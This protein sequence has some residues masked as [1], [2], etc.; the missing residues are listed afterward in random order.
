MTG[1]YSRW[2]ATETAAA[3]AHD[4]G[5]DPFACIPDP[6]AEYEGTV[7]ELAAPDTA[8]KECAP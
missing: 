3:L 1:D 2:L 8:P 4:T 7:L 5:R 6:S